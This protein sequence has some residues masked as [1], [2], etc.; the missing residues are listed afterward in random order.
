MLDEVTLTPH[1]LRSNSQRSIAC[2]LFGSPCRAPFFIAPTAMAGLIEHRG[3]TALAR[4]ATEAGLP[5]CLSTQ[6]VTSVT[7]LRAAVPS[8]D[9]WLQL[10]LWQEIALSYTLLERAAGAG[11]NVLVVTLDTPYG[12][13]KPWNSR[14][15]IGVPCRMSA[16][17]LLE[18]ALRPGWVSR[19]ILPALFT[20]GLP[21]FGN[22]PE[23]LRP[24]LFGPAPDPRVMLRRDLGWDDIARLREAWGGMLVFK[25]ILHPDDAEQACA[26]GADGIIVS[27]HGARNLDP[28]TAPIETLQEICAAVGHRMTVL[29]DSGVRNG[30]DAFK[31]R[32]KGARAV[33]LGRLPLYALAAGG[34][35]AVR[36]CLE[37]LV[38]DYREALDFSGA[39]PDAPGPAT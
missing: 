6:S 34:E 26:I 18:T 32:L 7:D 16:R 9:I 21:S 36:Q 12:A 14:R 30:L 3:E 5:V 25:G 35:G 37:Q 33:G 19:A 20:Q 23:T 31:Y 28:A 39:D 15:G 38:S 22:Y 17:N 8:A 13:R 11:V 29:A 4:A 2:D 27:S 1:V 24:K 10:Y